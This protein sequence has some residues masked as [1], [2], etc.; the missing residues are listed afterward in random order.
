MGR[1]FA[2]PWPTQVP[3]SPSSYAAA[4]INPPTL[5]F[6]LGQRAK[7]VEEPDEV[8]RSYIDVQTVAHASRN[9][10]SFNDRIPCDRLF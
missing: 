1:S 8:G 2:W 7:D 3:S 9:G 10:R 5:D 6:L 4:L